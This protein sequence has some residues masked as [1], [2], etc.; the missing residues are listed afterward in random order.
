[1]EPRP[2]LPEVAMIIDTSGNMG[3]GSIPYAST[4]LWVDSSGTTSSTNACVFRNSGGSNLMYV[5]SNGY[6]W[7]HQAWTTSDRRKKKNISYITD[8]ILPKIENLKFAKFDMIGALKNCYGFIAQDVETLFPDCIDDTK[9]P[10]VLYKASDDIPEGKEIGDV[11]EEGEEQKNLNY[12]YLF[13]HLVKAVQ[14]LSTKNT[15]LEAKV[16]ALENA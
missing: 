7:A 6:T 15:A 2:M 3:L 13:S 9:M 8:D 1:M 4:R 11:K 5:S 12:N 14:E 10:D 16:T